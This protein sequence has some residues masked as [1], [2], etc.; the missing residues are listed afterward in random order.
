MSYRV[1]KGAFRVVG[2]SPDGDSIRFAPDDVELVNTLPNGVGTVLPGK[3]VQLRLECIDALETHFMAGSPRLTHQPMGPAMAAREKLL[4]LLGFTGVQW[5]PDKMTVTGVDADDRP[6]FILASTFDSTGKR[7]VSYAFAGG[8]PAGVTDGDDTFLDVARL[9]ESANYRMVNQGF[10][11]PMYYEG[12]FFDLRAA[13]DAAVDQ[14]KAIGAADTIWPRDVT[15]S[16]FV[17]PP[18]ATLLDEKALWPKLFR[19]VSTY[20]KENP[21]SGLAGFVDWMAANR[22][23]CV[24]LDT[25]SWT[26]LHNFIAWDGAQI[27]MTKDIRRL[28]FKG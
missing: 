16:G 1:I 10:A 2:F 27:R 12:A 23:E 11:Y 3:S 22:D 8:L 25:G 20:L 28:M 15:N 7:P 13:F 9:V 19:R 17:V 4:D 24:D 6:G 18:D 5:S 14:A 26:A 21:D